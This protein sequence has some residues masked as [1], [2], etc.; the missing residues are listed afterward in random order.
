M[1]LL[2]G[3]D[4]KARYGTLEAVHGA[5]IVVNEGEIV[6]L[7]GPNGSGKSTI[8]KSI[9][10]TVDVTQGHIEFKGKDITRL[11][12]HERVRKGIGVV[13]QGN[14]LFRKMTIEENLEMGCLINGRQYDI[15]EI[16]R[17]LYKILTQNGDTLH[18]VNIPTNGQYL[19][20]KQFR[21]LKASSLSGGQQ[22]MLAIATALVTKPELLILDEPTLGLAPRL[23]YELFDVIQN[24]NNERKISIL[25][26]EQNT[27]FAQALAHRFYYLEDGKVQ[28]EG[29]NSY[30]SDK[31]E[32]MHTNPGNNVAVTLDK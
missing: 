25:L 8:L 4:I 31:I 18:L 23:I 9:L 11:S 27:E 12:A 2:K 19:S 24:L 15:Q 13:M 32:S 28:K 26:V 1:L 6:T 16:L 20:F 14:R 5:T 21:V 29:A 7:I 22:Q 3:T 17:W 30:L 10:G